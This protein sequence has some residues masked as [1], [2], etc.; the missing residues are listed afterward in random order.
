MMLAVPKV[1]LSGVHCISLVEPPT[2]MA[3]PC[4]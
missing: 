4:I 1:S 2:S 3:V